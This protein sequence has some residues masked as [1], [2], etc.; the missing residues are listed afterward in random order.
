MLLQARCEIMYYGTFYGTYYG[1]CYGTYVHSKTLGVLR[2]LSSMRKASFLAYE[3][4]L[5]TSRII[6][7]HVPHRND[8]LVIATEAQAVLAQSDRVFSCA[9]AIVSLQLSLR[10]RDSSITLRNSYIK[11]LRNAGTEF[12]QIPTSVFLIR[13]ISSYTIKSLQVS[14]V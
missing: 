12:A 11:K 3:A 10:N 13:G 8:I 6:R 4:S 14:R 9:H 2:F 5:G 7:S 1:T